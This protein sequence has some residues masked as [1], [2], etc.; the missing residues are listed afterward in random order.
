MNK[1][2]D[3]RDYERRFSEWGMFDKAKRLFERKGNGGETLPGKQGR[4]KVEGTFARRFTSDS[5]DGKIL[6]IE[7]KT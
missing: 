4:I 6:P 1:I 3:D 7:E 5:K 2:C